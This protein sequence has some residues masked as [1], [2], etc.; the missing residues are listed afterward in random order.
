MKSSTK[1]QHTGTTIGVFGKG[2]HSRGFHRGMLLALACAGLTVSLGVAQTVEADNLTLYATSF[3]QPIFPAGGQLLGRDGWSLTIPPFLNP[4]VATITGAAASNRK[5]SVEVRGGELIGSEGITA[6]YDAVGSYRRPLGYEISAEQSRV[7]VDANLLLET[8]QP[9]TPGEFFSLTIAARSGDGETLG[10]VGLSSQG[11]VEGF[12]FDVAPGSPPAV[13]AP[14]R[15]NQWYHLA[16]LLDYEKRTT[17]YY[18]DGQLLGTVDALSA[19]EVLLRVALVVYA[20]LD[21]GSAGGAGSARANYTARFDHLRVRVN[22]A[23]D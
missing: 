7:H 8:Q 14:I 3:E 5:Q 9:A 11:V 15:F 19:S 4:A 23:H 22:S 10:E 21:G 1:A 17:S 6:P 18:L 16:M 20:R 13:L 2:T 12:A